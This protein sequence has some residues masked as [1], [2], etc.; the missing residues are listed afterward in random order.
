LNLRRVKRIHFRVAAK[1]SNSQPAEVVAH[2]KIAL[3]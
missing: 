3:E 2:W 1:A